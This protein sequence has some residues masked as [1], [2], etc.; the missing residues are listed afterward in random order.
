MPVAVVSLLVGCGRDDPLNEPAERFEM[1][2]IDQGRAVRLSAAEVTGGELVALHLREPESDAPVWES[3]IAERDGRLQ[4]VRLGATRG[5]VLG[6]RPGPA[7]A[8]SER[9][10]LKRL[11]EETVLLPDEAA[12]EVADTKKGEVAT[13]MELERRNGDPVWTIGVLGVTDESVTVNVVDA[14]TGEVLERRPA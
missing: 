11:L 6:K 10:E 13:A 12:R 9:Q 4:T 2:E 1:V 5:E 3:R 8:G 14:R 7:L